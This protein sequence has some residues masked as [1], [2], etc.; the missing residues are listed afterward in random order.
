MIGLTVSMTLCFADQHVQL[1]SI[2]CLY[3]EVSM[4]IWMIR[5]LDIAWP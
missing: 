2:A 4:S 5:S 3:S 1:R